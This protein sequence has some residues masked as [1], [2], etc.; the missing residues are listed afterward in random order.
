MSRYGYGSSYSSSSSSD[1]DSL[2][3]GWAWAGIIATLIVCGLLNTVGKANYRDHV[4]T[5]TVTD[6]DRSGGSSSDSKYRVYTKQ[7]GVLENRDQWFAGKTN[8]ADIQGSIQPGKTYRLRVV[9]WRN[10]L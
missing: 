1:S 8:S 6:K 7:C 10:G 4:A 2:L 3:P 9:G 5:C